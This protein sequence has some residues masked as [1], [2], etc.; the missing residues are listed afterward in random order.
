MNCCPQLSWVAIFFNVPK[1]VLNTNNNKY[2]SVENSNF[3]SITV[4]WDFLFWIASLSFISIPLCC[5]VFTEEFVVFSCLYKSTAH[6][7]S[8]LQKHQKVALEKKPS[9]NPK[10]KFKRD[11]NWVNICRHHIL[12][13]GLCP[14]AEQRAALMYSC[15]VFP[16]HVRKLPCGDCH[17]LPPFVQFASERKIFKLKC[18]LFNT[19]HS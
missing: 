11:G 10:I 2:L 15:V 5:K 16:S 1:N 14:K 7:I 19:T 3:F 13:K 12:I 8:T 9:V 17:T 6:T 4:L 18:Q